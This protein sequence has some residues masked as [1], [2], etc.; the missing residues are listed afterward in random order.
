MYYRFAIILVATV[1][2]AADDQDAKKELDKLKGNWTVE[3]IEM[4]GQKTTG[5]DS[6]RMSFTVT[7]NKYAQ[8]VN[9]RT[10][11]EGTI[12]IDTSKKPP[13]IDL[14]ITSGMDKGKMQLGIYE[15]KDDTFKLAL[16]LPGGEKRPTAITG[17]NGILFV[18]KRE[19]EKDKEKEKK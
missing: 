7:D 14:N 13:T 3:S 2:V 5:E 11:E 17:D 18:L 19:K 15:L 16:N 1:L 10:I 9:G 8:K 12:K 6:G 4:D